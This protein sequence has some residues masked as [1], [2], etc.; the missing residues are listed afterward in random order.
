VHDEQHQRLTR[1]ERK[2]SWIAAALLTLIGMF[3]QNLIYNSPWSA[4]MQTV[5]S[6]ALWPG[7]LYFGAHFDK[8]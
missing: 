2:L 4:G 5:L 6:L 7:L 3:L 1:I 8:Y